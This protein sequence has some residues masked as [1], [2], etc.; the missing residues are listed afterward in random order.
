MAQA[1]FEPNLLLFNYSNYLILVI[2][3]A[4][5]DRE[6]GTDSVP[7]CRHIQFW[8]QGVTKKKEYNIQ[9]TAKV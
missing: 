8:H 7:R 6:D 3:P 4:Y 1:I 9:N 5:T 2:L